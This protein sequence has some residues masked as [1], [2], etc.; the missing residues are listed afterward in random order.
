[1]PK[2]LKES[3]EG[4]LKFRSTVRQILFLLLESLALSPK[5]A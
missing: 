1:M 5:I 2:F 3:V 4:K